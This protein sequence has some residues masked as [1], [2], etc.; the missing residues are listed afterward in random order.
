MPYVATRLLPE[1]ARYALKIMC[2][3]CDREELKKQKKIANRRQTDDR[4]K[5]R[6]E[7]AKR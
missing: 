6:R 1:P 2:L 3:Y 4:V 7:K 5:D